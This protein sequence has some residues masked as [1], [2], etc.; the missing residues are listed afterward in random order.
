LE[1]YPSALRTFEEAVTLHKALGD[2]REVALRL[3][4]IGNLYA[5]LGRT[6]P[7]T[8][9]AEQYLARALAYYQ[10]TLQI[11][12][13]LGD[14]TSEAELCRSIGNVLA[15]IGRY[16]DAIAHFERAHALFAMLGITQP[17]QALS[18]TIALAAQYRDA[19]KP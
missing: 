15:N 2:E 17:L 16:E 9:A 5:E 6:T 11:A 13:A 8:R 12:Q 3:G 1:H 7:D 18:E 14:Q 19:Q 10:E 4:V